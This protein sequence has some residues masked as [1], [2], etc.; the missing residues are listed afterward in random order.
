MF[1]RLDAVHGQVIATVE[2]GFRGEATAV[3]D[4]TVRDSGAALEP[5]RAVRA[6]RAVAVHG[7]L[8]SNG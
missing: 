2:A 6:L 7:L 8:N 4:A 1:A 5:A 3:I